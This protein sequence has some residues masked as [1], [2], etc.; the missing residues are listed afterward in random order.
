MAKDQDM[1]RQQG[2][3]MKNTIV[4]LHLIPAEP[5]MATREV[6]VQKEKKDV[7]KIE[8][9]L[10]MISLVKKSGSREKE[11]QKHVA[12]RPAEDQDI[13]QLSN[14]MKCVIETVTEVEVVVDLWTWMEDIAKT[15]ETPMVTLRSRGKEDR[16]MNI[17]TIAVENT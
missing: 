9:K 6:K 1:K 17:L 14:R 8:T 10:E 5:P 13:Q 16:R 7:T 15:K 3:P 4:N 11:K 12:P 2:P